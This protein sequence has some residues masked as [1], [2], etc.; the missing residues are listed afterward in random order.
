M[1]C[2]NCGTELDDEKDM[3]VCY[4]HNNY[5]CVWCAHDNEHNCKDTEDKKCNTGN[6][7]YIPF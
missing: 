1:I 7:W 3:L 2:P 6:D 5:Y 4:N